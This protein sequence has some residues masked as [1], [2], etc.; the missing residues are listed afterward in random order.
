MACAASSTSCDRTRKTKGGPDGPPPRPIVVRPH[1]TA[2]I[3]PLFFSFYRT[4]NTA[5]S[6]SWSDGVTPVASFVLNDCALAT[7]RNDAVF[8]RKM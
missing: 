1:K 5:S 7:F 8:E 3:R 4:L 6:G 2:G